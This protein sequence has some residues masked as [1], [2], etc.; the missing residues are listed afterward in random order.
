[1]SSPP[2]SP[3]DPPRRQP[4][5]EQVRT[6][7]QRVSEG[8]Q[9]E[10]LWTQFSADAKATYGIYSRDVAWAEVEKKKGFA[11]WLHI[12]KEFFWALLLKLSPARRV[13]FIIAVACFILS[14]ILFN[15]GGNFVV[16]FEFEFIAAL[17][18]FVL[19][20]FADRV[21]MKRDLEI[22]REIQSRLVPSRPPD[23]PGA[24]IAF[25]AR[26]QNTVAGDYYDASIP[27]PARLKAGNS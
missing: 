3:T 9:I 23:I 4:F 24:E 19:L 11:R 26:P 12:L 7:W 18:F 10:D 8:R 21:T 1:M 27:V 25:A 22:A 6:F 2:P 20:E 16:A 17:L 14:G 15:F 13:L 5:L